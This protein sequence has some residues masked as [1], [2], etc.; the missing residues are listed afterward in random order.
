MTSRSSKRWVFKGDRL[1]DHLEGTAGALARK[2][3][4]LE[5]GGARPG[6]FMLAKLS[7]HLLHLHVDNPTRTR[8]E[9][10]SSAV[11]GG[12]KANSNMVRGGIWMAAA[13]FY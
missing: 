7:N 12:H 10:A 3:G 9:V 1:G 2:R 6:R 5:G 4:A 11:R 13:A 8:P